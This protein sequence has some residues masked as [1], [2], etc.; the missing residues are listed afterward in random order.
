MRASTSGCV[1]EGDPQVVVERPVTADVL[2]D[3]ADPHQ[4]PRGVMVGR[5]MRGS[6]S[7]ATV[8]F[9][10]LVGL[11]AV[12]HR[13]R[14]RASPSGPRAD[15]AAGPVRDARRPTRSVGIAPGSRWKRDPAGPGD[16]QEMADIGV[17]WMRLGF[18]WAVVEPQRGRVPLGLRSTRSCDEADTACLSVLAMVGTTP[19]W[20]R[21]PRAAGRCGARRGTSTSSPRSCGPSPSATR[22][23]I[24]RLGGLERAELRGLV[25]PRA[26][27]RA[28][29]P[30]ARGG[31]R[32]PS[33]A[34]DP[35]ATVLS[36]GLAPSP[37]GQPRHRMLPD[38]FLDEL[39]DTGAMDAVDACRLPP[40]Q[41]P[42]P[43]VAADRPERVHRSAAGDARGRWSTTATTTKTCG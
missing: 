12:R 37:S 8:A 17:R 21:E 34:V 39:Y 16:M 31:D 11:V 18:E 9:L 2:V 23:P 40:V 4:A 20:A 32:P 13:R 41:L 3:E 29:R 30:A 1:L 27:S 15:R 22:R 28:L 35:D 10:I 7:V 14:R 19:Q 26:R 5:S 42:V 33:R 25:P 6:R 24:A 36:A 43:A 38:R